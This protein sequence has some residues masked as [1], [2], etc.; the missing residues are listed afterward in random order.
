MA[1]A[2]TRANKV[3]SH[4]GQ[5]WRR[6][7]AST[8]S[9]PIVSTSASI[10]GAT[11][12]AAPWTAAP[13]ATTPMTPS[14]TGTVRGRVTGFPLSNGPLDGVGIAGCCCD[15][16]LKVGDGRGGRVTLY[17]RGGPPHVGAPW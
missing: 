10:V 15:M 5:L 17:R 4:P 14:I 2:V 3:P 13:M 6:A 11:I 12:P 9:T 16:P 8:G 1:Y 7:H